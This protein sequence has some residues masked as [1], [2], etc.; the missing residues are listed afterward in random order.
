M[1]GLE[2]TFPRCK[3][4][5][6]SD[7]ALRRLMIKAIVLVQNF[8]TDYV[9]YSQIQTA[10]DA[11]YVRIK[12]LQGYDRIAQYYFRPGEYDSKV[13]G[14]GVDDEDGGSEEE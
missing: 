11:E 5:L 3:K 12:N 10:F 13:D 6:P 1:R 7:P 2:D 4:R 8:R 9:G 14:E